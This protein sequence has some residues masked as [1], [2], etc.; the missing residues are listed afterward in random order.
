[1]I[2]QLCSTQQN[3]CFAPH[4]SFWPEYKQTIF[5]C[6]DATDRPSPINT[7]TSCCLIKRS[8]MS[9]RLRKALV[10]PRAAGALT[11]DGLAVKENGVIV[12]LPDCN[13]I[14]II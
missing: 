11:L 9:A 4:G 10:S 14:I 12:F 7:L 8:P 3:V 6:S 13:K 2:T 5:S 1:M